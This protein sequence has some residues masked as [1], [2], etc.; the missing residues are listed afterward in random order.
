MVNGQLRNGVAALDPSN[1]ALNAF[2]PALTGGI[3]ETVHGASD[4]LFIG[5]GFTGFNGFLGRSHAVY[6]ACTG[7]EWFIDADGDGYGAPAS[8][9]FACEEPPGMID[10]AEDCDDSDPLLFIGAACDDGDPYSE[11]DAIDIACTCTGKFYAIEARV[12]LN[13]PY[14]SN[15]SLMR[16]DLRA[17]SLCHSQ[18]PF[19][20]P[21]LRARCA[22][23]YREQ[24]GGGLGLSGSARPERAEPGDRYT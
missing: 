10:Q 2:D 3:A 13:G 4:H 21:G 15:V 7:S 14:V 6:G 20:R 23:R 22:H 11:F 12:F 16:D 18:N 17:A 8:M 24:R 9:V 1:G 19:L 5:G